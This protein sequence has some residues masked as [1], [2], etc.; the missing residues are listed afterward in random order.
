MTARTRAAR[1]L[2]P[3]TSLSLTYLRAFRDHWDGV[4]GHKRAVRKAEHMLRMHWSIVG[5]DAA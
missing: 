2:D 5:T 4:R 3:A 1:R